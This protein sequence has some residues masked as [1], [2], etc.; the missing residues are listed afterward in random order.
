M[1]DNLTNNSI[2]ASQEEDFKE[3]SPADLIFQLLD[4]LSH[5]RSKDII[6]KRFGLDGN[7]K[8]T[9]E[10]IGKEYGITRER[11]RQIEASTL[12]ELKKSKGVK[13]VEP[14]EESLESLLSEH[15][16]LMGHDELVEKC[17]EKLQHEKA[18]GNL[19]EFI[20]KLS[21]RFVDF[22]E[23]EKLKK[24]WGLK[25]SDIK[26]AEKIIDSAAKSL[27]EENKPFSEN[28]FTALISSNS[29]LTEEMK[30]L[31]NNRALL[32][33]L[34]LSKKIQKNPYN[35][36][37]LNHW[38]E[39]MPRGVRDKAYVVLKKN[40]KPLH[41]R[42]ITEM[43]NKKGFSKRQANMQTVH[44][45]LIKDSRFILVGRGIYALKEWGY[46]EG[47]VKD[48]IASILKKESEPLPKNK[49]ITEV[50]KQR[51]VKENTIILTLQDKNLFQRVEKGTYKLAE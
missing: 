28:K 25:S 18:H 9:L 48:I 43:I 10:E 24:A 17:I 4:E 46:R 45:E 36:W 35:E 29:D 11:V 15:G 13:H 22:K 8:K 12:A 27:E 21:D 50:L 31:G 41:F 19:I 47:T 14:L 7:K 39:I 5:K 6:V 49:I 37:G 38:S 32:S 23:N 20:L 26:K 16:E 44:N 42:G 1:K 30:L 3:L 51:M 34:N 2:D 33:Y 40:S